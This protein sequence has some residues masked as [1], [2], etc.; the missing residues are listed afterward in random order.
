VFESKIRRIHSIPDTTPINV[1]YSDSDGDKIA[2]DTDEELADLIRQALQSGNLKPTLRFDVSPREIQSL[3]SNSFVFV[4][5]PT[6][7]QAV[8]SSLTSTAAFTADGTGSASVQ[9]PTEM[10]ID[11]VATTPSVTNIDNDSSATGSSSSASTSDKGKQRADAPHVQEEQEQQKPQSDAT[12]DTKEFSGSATD[13]NQREPQQ[14]EQQQPKHHFETLFENLQPLF[15]ELST[16]FEKSNLG[17]ILE[18]VHFDEQF[19]HF[20]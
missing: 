5:P 9:E 4:H 13:N 3:D 7:P 19:K 6:P 15:S 11:T 20:M 8:S 12:R 2:L 14:E 16:E 1:T 18:K 17:P 10:D